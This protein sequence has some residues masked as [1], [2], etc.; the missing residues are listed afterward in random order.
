MFFPFCPRSTRT[1][2][3]ERSSHSHSK[4]DSGAPLALAP[5]WTGP[6][7]PRAYRLLEADVRWAAVEG[8][9]LA[10]LP[11][12]LGTLQVIEVSHPQEPSLK[13]CPCPSHSGDVS[14]T[15]TGPAVTPVTHSREP[16]GA[17]R[18]EQ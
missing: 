1:A 15:T 16:T 11:G 7:G 6:C 12:G 3:R 8:S 18:S 13:T 14:P 17:G 5:S 4:E 10:R 2:P 9:I